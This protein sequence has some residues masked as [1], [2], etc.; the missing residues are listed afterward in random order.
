MHPFAFTLAEVD[1]GMGIELWRTPMETGGREMGCIAAIVW[2]RPDGFLCSVI[3]DEN[4]RRP[5]Q[6][7]LRAMVVLRAFSSIPSEVS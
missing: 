7:H 5:K 6:W 2:S 4:V 1:G 3:D